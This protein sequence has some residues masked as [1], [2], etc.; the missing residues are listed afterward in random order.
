MKLRHVIGD[1]LIVLALA[2]TVYLSVIMSQRISTVVLKSD[3]TKIFHYELIFCLVFL[4]F[5]ADVRFS[6]LTMM[7]FKAIKAVGWLLRIILVLA[8]AVLLFF[9]GKICIGSFIQTA[10]PTKYAIVL[11]LA[12]ENGEPVPD[13][14]SRLDTAEQYLQKNPESSVILTGGNA[15]ASGKTEAAVMHDILSARGV[16]EDRMILEDKADTTKT[17]FRNTAQL[18][19]P[20]SPVVLISSNYHMDRAVQ[21]AKGAGFSRILRLPAPSSA[22]NFVSNVMYEVVLELNELT[23]KQ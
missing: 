17:N 4:L 7:R 18:I 11:G 6:F 22:V 14:L 23:L 20:D 1:I 10:E 19:D 9:T 3:Y 5:A 12:L 16:A 8:V 15:D 13:L 21:T 2:L